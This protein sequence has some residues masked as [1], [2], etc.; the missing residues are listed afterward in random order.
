MERRPPVEVLRE[1]LQEFLGRNQEASV[2]VGPLGTVVNKPWNDESLVLVADSDNSELL[3]A[4]NAVKLPPRFTALWHEDTKDLEVIYTLVPPGSPLHS[5]RFEF[6]F[7]GVTYKCGFGPA[8]ARL[9]TIALSS[10]PL[11]RPSRTSHRNLPRIF[12]FE[13]SQLEHPGNNDIIRR[14]EPTSFWIDGIEEY[15][16]SMITDLVRN[17]NFYMTYFDRNSPR[18]LVHEEATAG[19]ESRVDN[20]TPP[21]FPSIVTG[22]DIDQ[23]LLSLWESAIGGDIFLRFLHYYQIL[24]YAAFYY[25]KDEVMQTIHQILVTPDT[26]AKPRE[27]A[28]QIL[29]AVVAERSQDEAKIRDVILRCVNTEELW[30]VIEDNRTSFDQEVELDGGF[31]LPPIV[32]ANSGIEEFQKSWHPSLPLTLQR[33]RNGLVHARE[34]RQSTMISPTE[35]N[36][37]RLYPWL[38]PLSLIAA[39]V[40][41]YRNT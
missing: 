6:R 41:L 12:L 32:A 2:D 28:Q 35:S 34:S 16:D 21:E 9:R 8:S 22:G 11:G 39:H 29:D 17:L 31:L 10:N 3:A 20:Y 1:M 36:R 25:I 4:L 37:N 14:G 24:E 26:A 30:K 33:I 19:A 7:R 18:I 15:D 5:R 13:R 27:A 40:M 23:H 38:A